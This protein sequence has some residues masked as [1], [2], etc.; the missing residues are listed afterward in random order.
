[1]V[2][3]CF[4]SFIIL[5]YVDKLRLVWECFL[6]FIWWMNDNYFMFWYVDFIRNFIE[7][8]IRVFDFIGIIMYMIIFERVESYILENNEENGYVM[9][10]NWNFKG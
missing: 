9:L 5:R 1:M 4:W 10:I 6:K 7:I 2:F 8:L 3:V